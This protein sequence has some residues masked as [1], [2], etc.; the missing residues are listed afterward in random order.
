MKEE[1]FESKLVDFLKKN[2]SLETWAS[3]KMIGGEYGYSQ[4]ILTTKLL[5][6]VGDKQI[7]ISESETDLPD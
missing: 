4:K 7:V 1:D 2:L 3:D 5:L 6:Q